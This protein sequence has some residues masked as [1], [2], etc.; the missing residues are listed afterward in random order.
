MF[1]INNFIEIFKSVIL[2]Y[3]ILSKVLNEP[4]MS[5]SIIIH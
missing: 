2:F 5:A 1:Q 3:Q 4:V